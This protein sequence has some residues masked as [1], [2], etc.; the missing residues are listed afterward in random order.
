MVVQ[1]SALIGLLK[2]KGW[3]RG[4]LSRRCAHVRSSERGE[5]STKRTRGQG[6]MRCIGKPEHRCCTRQQ[7]Y[8]ALCPA[9]LRRGGARAT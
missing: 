1:S 3:S 6:V 7:S 5:G 9:R 8:D 4:A 2:L